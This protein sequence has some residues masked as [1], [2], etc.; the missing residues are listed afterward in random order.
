MLSASY[1][2][3]WIIALPLSSWFLDEPAME[4]SDHNASEGYLWH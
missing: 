2:E 3:Q 1:L 4:Q